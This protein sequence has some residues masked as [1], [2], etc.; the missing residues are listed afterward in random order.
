M[1]IKKITRKQWI[2]STKETKRW[3]K[4]LSL[5]LERSCIMNKEKYIK[6]IK[7]DKILPKDFKEMLIEDIKNMSDKEFQ[8]YL[9][10]I[11]NSKIPTV[12]D[13]KEQWK[14]VAFA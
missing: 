1:L 11:K 13:D 10:E 14:V 5:L 6:D 4:N 3:Q 7:N 8:E 9:K 2:K 12:L